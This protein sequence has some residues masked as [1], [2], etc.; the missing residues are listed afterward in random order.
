[1]CI[2]DSSCSYKEV[3]SSIRNT[4]HSVA[5]LDRT[6]AVYGPTAIINTG[7]E[8]ARESKKV[9]VFVPVSYNS[10]EKKIIGSTVLFPSTISEMTQY[11]VENDC[12]YLETKTEAVN[13]IDTVSYTHLPH[14]YTSR[15]KSIMWIT[16]GTEILE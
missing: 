14:R 3:A 7:T 8:A 2:R 1:M 6:N 15:L 16:S 9:P 4:T 10:E 13:G 11:E 5:L 12:R